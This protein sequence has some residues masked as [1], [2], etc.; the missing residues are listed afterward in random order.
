MRR[1]LP[2]ILFA[3]GLVLVGLLTV[4]RQYGTA[5]ATQ[6]DDYPEPQHFVTVQVLEPRHGQIYPGQDVTLRLKIERPS[7]EDRSDIALFVQLDDSWVTRGGSLVGRRTPL[8]MQT[9]E[10]MITLRTKVSRRGLHAL[11]VG[12]AGGSPLTNRTF[13]NF[14][15][16]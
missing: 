12:T 15:T 10:T 3:V 5:N 2:K 4:V 6:P 16:R 1:R 8:Q 11:D 13:L 7:I 9:G 14:G